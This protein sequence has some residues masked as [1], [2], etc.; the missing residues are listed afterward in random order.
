VADTPSDLPTPP[1]G[2]DFS[3]MPIEDALQMTMMLIAEDA[4]KDTKDLLEVMDSIRQRVANGD[5]G[6]PAPGPTAPGWGG[7]GIAGWLPWLATILVAGIAGTALGLSGVFGVPTEEVTVLEST[8]SVI[9][10]APAYAC[11][12]GPQVGQLRG[13]DHVVAVERSDDSAYLG[14][15]NPY[16]VGDVLW[17]ATS[18]VVVDA[19]QPAI[20]GLPVGACPV[21]AVQYGTPTPT[22]DPEPVGD[23]SAPRI[24]QASGTTPFYSA[25]GQS[26]TISAVATDD[27]GVRRITIAVTRPDGATSSAE[28]TYVGGE[29]F[30]YVYTPGGGSP[31]G[32]YRFVLTAYDSAGNA[33]ASVEVTVQGT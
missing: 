11:P 1:S 13:G 3:N 28:M 6:T 22:P 7:G 10:V 31:T 17:L 21:V 19:G 2:P 26:T 33:S 5:T 4:K 8:A 23:T 18:V 24:L 27:V 14:V 30:S 32:T 20:S 9:T 15:R 29:N 25:N 12:G 16:N